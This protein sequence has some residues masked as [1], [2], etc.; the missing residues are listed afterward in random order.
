VTGR[1]GV[2]ETGRK[3]GRWTGRPADRVRKK[4]R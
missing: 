1:N 2:R 4:G 3:G